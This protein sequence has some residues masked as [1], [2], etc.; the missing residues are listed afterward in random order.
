MRCKPTRGKQK[1]Y[2][3][4]CSAP[5]HKKKGDFMAGT[6]EICPTSCFVSFSVF[7]SLWSGVRDMTRPCLLFHLFSTSFKL[8]LRKV[9]ALTKFSLQLDP[10]PISSFFLLQFDAISLFDHFGKPND[11]TSNQNKAKQSNIDQ[12]KI[13]FKSLFKRTFKLHIAIISVTLSF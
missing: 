5:K 3:I 8:S 13:T 10:D 11:L 12:S 9:S 4:L 6:L 2:Q 7:L 1:N